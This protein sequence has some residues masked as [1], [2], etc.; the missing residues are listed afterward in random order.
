MKLNLNNY[1]KIIFDMDGVITSEYIYWDAAALTVYELLLSHEYYG[2]GGIDREWC[3]KN[4]KLITEIV[5][6][7]GDTI[8]A[9][10]K[11]GVNTNWDLAYVVFCASK[12]LDPYL[13]S[14]DRGHFESVC[15]FIEN[16]TAKAPDVYDALAGLASEAM[17]CDFSELKRGGS[18]LWNKLYN[19]FQAWFNGAGGLDGLCE[20]EEPL[21]PIDSISSTLK[22]LNDMGKKLGIGTGRPKSEIEYPL[23]KWDIAKYFNSSMIV[24]YDDVL[25][26]ENKLGD[27]VRLG[28]PNPFMFEKASGGGDNVLVVGDAP[29]DLI[30]AKEAGYDFAAVLTGID[31]E[32]AREYFEKNG[33]DYIFEDVTQLCR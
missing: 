13:E 21:L 33:A 7:S 23:R 20:K 27:G 25:S 18:P 4:Y 2:I 22:N 6:S 30:S 9:V 24:T 15:I 10:K 11:L 19:V 3:A 32:D 31:G 17:G 14:F 8:S 1:D 16:I 29:S 28:K 5:F 12:Y 26:E